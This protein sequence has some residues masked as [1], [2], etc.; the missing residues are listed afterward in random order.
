MKRHYSIPNEADQQLRKSGKI[1]NIITFNGQGRSG[2]TTQAEQLVKL[3]TNKYIYAMSHTLRDNFKKNFYEQLARSDQQLQQE[4][5]GIP[6]LSWLTADFHWRIKPLLLR[7]FTIVF[8]HYLGDYYADMLPNG[9]A[10]NFQ[11]FVRKNLAIPHFEHGTHF[12]LD[13]DYENYKKRADRP[14]SEWFSVDSKDL[15][16]ERR[17]RYHELCNLEYLTCI[18]AK[19]NEE[20][21]AKRIQEILHHQH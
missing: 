20:T 5:L 13:I 9:T 6:S 2:K 18:D 10:E 17:A 19:E 7:N 12:Y 3:D 16:E 1:K 8:D 15:F 4:I 11:C 14:E 21:V